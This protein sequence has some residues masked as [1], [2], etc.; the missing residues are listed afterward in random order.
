M[1]AARFARVPAIDLRCA[2]AGHQQHVAE[3]RMPAAE[4][5]VCEKPRMLRSPY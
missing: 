1:A 4:K 2:D 5:C 3:I